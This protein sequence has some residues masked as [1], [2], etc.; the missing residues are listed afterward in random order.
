MTQIDVGPGKERPKKSP[1]K[2]GK[3]GMEEAN[4]KQD[5]ETK[6]KEGKRGKHQEEILKNETVGVQEHPCRP[7]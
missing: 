1:P 6:R 5:I 4:L 7:Q 2:L 3:R